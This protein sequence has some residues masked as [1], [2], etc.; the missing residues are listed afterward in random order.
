M[1]NDRKEQRWELVAFKIV[2]LPAPVISHISKTY[3]SFPSGWFIISFPG[4]G[5]QVLTATADDQVLVS[6]LAAG[7]A[8]SAFAFQL[9]T[10]SDG[11]LINRGKGATL[12]VKDRDIFDNA[13][14]TT[15]SPR[16]F[17]AAESQ[18]FLLQIDPAAAG[19]Y[20]VAVVGNESYVVSDGIEKESSGVVSAI[21]GGIGNI[22]GFGKKKEEKHVG[23]LEKVGSKGFDI[24]S[25]QVSFKAL[26]LDGP[27][28]KV[29]K[30][31]DVSAGEITNNEVERI[32]KLR[33][34]AKS[35]SSWIA[36]LYGDD[37]PLLRIARFPEGE[38]FI[39]FREWGREYVV[40]TTSLGAFHTVAPG[41]SIEVQPLDR[42]NYRAQ[43]WRFR[44][45][46]KLQNVESGIVMDICD[47]KLVHG[48]KLI[49]W[50]A[51]DVDDSANQTFV[52]GSDRSIM[53]AED[54]NLVLG[55]PSPLPTFASTDV[56]AGLPIALYK[57]DSASEGRKTVEFLYPVFKNGEVCGWED[58]EAVVVDEDAVVINFGQS[59]ASSTTKIV[60]DETAGFSTVQTT[61][62]ETDV[63]ES[64]VT[65]TTTTAVESTAAEAT[66]TAMSAVASTSATNV[67]E[68]TTTV[69]SYVEQDIRKRYALF[70]SGVFLIYFAAHGKD[71]VLTVEGNAVCVS[72]IDGSKIRYQLW[73]YIDGF[74]VNF[75][76]GLVLDLEGGNCVAGAKLIASKRKA[77]ISSASAQFGLFSTG[78]FFFTANEKLTISATSATTIVSATVSTSS[79]EG[80]GILIPR[81]KTKTVT[82]CSAS[83]RTTDVTEVDYESYES[84][85]SYTLTVLS[86][87]WEEIE[88]I[89]SQSTT[90]SW[91]TSAYSLASRR[92]EVTLATLPLGEF[93]LC[94]G[95]SG[96]EYTVLTVAGSKVVAAALSYQDAGKQLWRYEDGGKIVNV[97]TGYALDV[98]GSSG[99]VVV[100]GEGA[101][102]GFTTGGELIVRERPSFVVCSGEAD[103]VSLVMRDT[104]ESVRYK[105]VVLYVR[106]VAGA[107]VSGSAW[108]IESCEEI[109]H[110]ETTE[111]IKE[112]I[113][114]TITGW[115]F[116]RFNGLTLI[117][118]LIHWNPPVLTKYN[119]ISQRKSAQFPSEWCLIYCQKHGTDYVLDVNPDDCVTIELRKFNPKARDSQ[120]WKCEDGVWINQKYGNVLVPGIPFVPSPPSSS[121]PEPSDPSSSS[122]SSRISSIFRRSRSKQRS[123]SR[124]KSRSRSKSTSRL[125]RIFKSKRNSVG[126]DND[127][128]DPEN[129]PPVGDVYP[130]DMETLKSYILASLEDGAGVKIAEADSRPVVETKW[131]IGRSSGI[132]IETAT[133]K[134]YI[135]AEAPVDGVGKVRLALSTEI[136]TRFTWGFRILTIKKVAKQTAVASP[137]QKIVKSRR[138]LLSKILMSYSFCFIK[139][140]HSQA[141]SSCSASTLRVVLYLLCRSFE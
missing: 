84:C 86:T 112:D 108:A 66:A 70:P 29:V 106:F 83:G 62:T 77:R 91:L 20:R 53:L 38:F 115:L 105:I 18:N 117:I 61:S 64:T 35:W 16:T 92:D 97:A 122:S 21:A 32:K 60:V 135:G 107:R 45:D 26:V 75:A 100:D 141:N 72:K 9:W 111:T 52:L 96:K 34:D 58:K 82:K 78:L 6:T 73:E 132:C 51:K 88:T 118:E 90:S 27:D 93:S 43:L 123:S 81:F 139:S 80:I 99:V 67:A 37:I 79:T 41:A 11:F 47:N 14:L 129:A 71:L 4:L 57:R 133:V 19:K 113:R 63:I 30:V 136:D 36:S 68:T 120:M 89:S 125:S 116:N 127:D 56:L 138:F 49:Q 87:S 44:R 10:H 15:T 17:R 25:A 104:V 5:N 98:D 134:L 119:V 94:I 74:L 69:T 128:D 65:G 130:T 46:G 13:G 126:D 22:V 24:K 7:A 31:E 85:E 121:T 109:T 1:F 48:T 131:R 50:H 40:G 76:S 102:W 12:D 124:S 23:V 55:V 28:E 114:T 2:E 54:V 103:Q 140:D 101:K 8:S 3:A 110:Y 33:A 95:T 59:S 137:A 42:K 39:G